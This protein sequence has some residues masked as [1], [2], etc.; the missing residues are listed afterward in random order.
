MH[1]KAI[2]NKIRDKF[3]I[4]CRKERLLCRHRTFAFFCVTAENAPLAALKS[5]FL[6]NV[7]LSR[8]VQELRC[9]LR[10]TEH[11]P[12]QNQRRKTAVSQTCISTIR[13]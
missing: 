13:E 11:I 2:K 10:R 8:R 5:F 6:H 4:D 7:K 9:S 3:V 1:N 12:S